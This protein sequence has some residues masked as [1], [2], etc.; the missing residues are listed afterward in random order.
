MGCCIRSAQAGLWHAPNAAR[1]LR[2]SLPALTHLPQV[3]Q[4][5]D[6]LAAATGFTVCVP[7]VWHG[8][9]R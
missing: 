6:C 8:K 2:R 4:L 1:S 3:K 5:A 7:D 9:V